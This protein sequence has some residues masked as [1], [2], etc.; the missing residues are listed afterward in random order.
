MLNKLDFFLKDNNIFLSGSA[1]VGKSFLTT[2][3]V[4]LYRKQGRIVVVL[5]STGLSAFNIGGVTLHSFLLL[6]DVK[7]MMSYIMKIESKGIN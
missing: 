1:G 7:I 5:G 3:L 6:K 4:K 2:E